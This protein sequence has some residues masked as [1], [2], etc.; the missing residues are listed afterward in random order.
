MRKPYITCFFFS[1][2]IPL[3]FSQYG[4]HV[5]SGHFT[6]RIEYNYNMEA[7][8]NLGSKD[9]IELL[10]LGDFNASA[11]FFYSPYLNSNPCSPA[12]FRMYRDSLDKSYIL[13]IKQITNFESMRHILINIYETIG[14]PCVLIS[15][16]PEDVREKI[17]K[18]HWLVNPRYFT[19]FSNQFRV[20]TQSFTISDQFAE[21]VYKYIV[22][23][24]ATFQAKGKPPPYIADGYS[25]KFRTVKDDLVWTLR[26]YLPQGNALKLSNLCREIITDSSSDKFDEKKYISAFCSLEN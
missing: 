4:V 15:S 5:N 18:H 21:T 2:F 24:T 14:I 11:E 7:D 16:V 19:N 1:I 25:V 26:I 8:F 9:V 17:L 13:E 6:K 3:L 20:E 10:L 22:S 23:F 12:G